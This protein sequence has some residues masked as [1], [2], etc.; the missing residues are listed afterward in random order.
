MT[1][2]TTRRRRAGPPP[3]RTLVGMIDQLTSPTGAAIVLGEILFWVLLGAGLAA[4]YLLRAPRA[5]A[6]L[7]T[8][9]LLVDVGILGVAVADIRS[10]AAATFVHG[11]SALYVGCS[12]AFGRSVVGW[13]DVRAAHRWA[14]GPA[15]RRVPRRGRERAAHEWRNFARWLLGG[16][17]A[18]VLLGLAVV[19]AGPGA[20]VAALRDW[21]PRLLI[22]T[23]V[24]F[25]TGPVWHL[26]GS[27]D[28]ATTDAPAPGR[29]RS[30]ASS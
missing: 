4:R 26:G 23:V 18:A 12:V 9:T 17:I 15:P 29:E 28:E 14:G 27:D 22:I 24:W 6:A 10:G 3:A 19:I 30:D 7:L 25:A 11:L 5:G 16:A 8:A 21:F 20:D 2:G 1:P 13:A